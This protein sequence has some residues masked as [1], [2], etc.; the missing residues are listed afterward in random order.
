MQV[1]LHRSCPVDFWIEQPLEAR[2]IAMLDSVEHVT[3]SWYLLRH[4]PLDHYWE[5]RHI[6]D[7]HSKTGFLRDVLV[8]T[9]SRLAI[10]R[11]PA[12]GLPQRIAPQSALQRR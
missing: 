5:G 6:F 8:A 2:P 7:Y 4:L 9:F 3:D 10:D 11:N 12:A 1:L